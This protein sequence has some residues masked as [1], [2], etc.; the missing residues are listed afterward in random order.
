MQWFYVGEHSHQVKISNVWSYPPLNL[1]WRAEQVSQFLIGRWNSPTKLVLRGE[2]FTG[3]ES[4][5]W[6]KPWHRLTFLANTANSLFSRCETGTMISRK[7]SSHCLVTSHIFVIIKRRMS[8]FS[9]LG[10]TSRKYNCWVA[11]TKFQ[12]N[13][14]CGLYMTYH[15][16]IPTPTKSKNL[17]YHGSSV[18]SFYFCR[19]V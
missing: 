1:L 18:G 3:G 7:V 16:D 12:E 15:F 5:I 17:G 6:L 19:V 11:V 2:V 8:H 13:Y 4:C 9:D 10:A 14:A